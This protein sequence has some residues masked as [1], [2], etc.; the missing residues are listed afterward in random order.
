M[1]T[2]IV[3]APR[4]LV[5]P[6][7]CDIISSLLK[8]KSE[9]PAAGWEETLSRSVRGVCDCDWMWRNRSLI[10]GKMNT[11]PPMTV[12]QSLINTQYWR[13]RTK[14][15]IVV[16]IGAGMEILSRLQ[17]RKC[18]SL[19]HHRSWMFWRRSWSST[20]RRA[21]SR[22]C[23]AAPRRW[24]LGRGW[25]PSS[26][27]RRGGAGQGRASNKDSRRIHNHGEGPY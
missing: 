19:K 26:A 24:S 22:K 2:A 21:S 16:D 9:W 25:T 6:L 15:K 18:L 20:T 11:S 8:V 27:S 17:L 3:L 23:T 10:D 12:E 7:P 4:V 1:D 13:I 5:Q 14:D